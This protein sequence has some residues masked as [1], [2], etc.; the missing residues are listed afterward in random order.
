MNDKQLGLEDDDLE[1]II[2][3]LRKYPQIE[4]ALIFGS[5]AKGEFKPGSDV[6]IALVGTNAA[7]VASEISFSL[8]EDSLLP[9]KFDVLHCSSLSNP[10][11]VD[12]IMR[13]GI[14]I[15]EKKAR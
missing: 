13:V 10:K 14:V 11:L 3:V 5:R 4:K 8:N 2:A 15:Y 6:D 7:D 1:V 9:Y 12:H